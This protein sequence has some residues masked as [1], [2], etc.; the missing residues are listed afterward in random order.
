VAVSAVGFQTGLRMPIA[1]MAARCHARGAE[2]SVD[3]VQ[4]CGVVPLDVTALGIDYL[5]CGSHKWLMGIE[6]AGFL[7]VRRERLAALR[8]RVAGWLSHEDGLAFLM[9][10]GGQLR[11]DRP[12]RRRIDFLEGHNMSSVGLAALDASVDLILSIG[13]DAISPHVASYL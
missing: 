2:L 5:A 9:S 13:V 8:P 3:A 1:E 6:G 7:W 12:I 11:Y 4:A 10:G